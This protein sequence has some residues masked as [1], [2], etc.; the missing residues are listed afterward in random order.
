M[1]RFQLGSRTLILNTRT[2]TENSI[3]LNVED[4][5]IIASNVTVCSRRL[6]PGLFLKFSST[7]HFTFFSFLFLFCDFQSRASWNKYFLFL[8]VFNVWS[9]VMFLLFGSAEPQPWAEP[10]LALS[11]GQSGWRKRVDVAGES[12]RRTTF[13][14]VAPSARA[15]GQR[16]ELLVES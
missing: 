5:N 4:G 12:N 15:D 14:D 16:F 13:E 10:V 8:S 11:A 3:K 1:L 6:I 2:N 7:F 9:L